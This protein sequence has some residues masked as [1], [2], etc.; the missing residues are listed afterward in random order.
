[1]LT[2]SPIFDCVFGP[3]R[4]SRRSGWRRMQGFT[5]VELLAVL[6]IVGVLAGILIPVVAGVRDRSRTAACASNLRQIGIGFRVYLADNKGLGLK[7]YI[8]SGSE[9]WYRTLLGSSTSSAVVDSNVLPACPSADV[10]GSHAV[11]GGY[12]M[13]NLVVWYPVPLHRVDSD[14]H[15]FST[16]LQRPQDWPLFMDADTPIIYGLDNPVE[17]AAS[18][19]RF[20]ARHGGKANVLM[21]DLHMESVGYGDSRWSQSALN[22]GSYYTP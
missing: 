13:T 15:F 22:S 7:S 1:M 12:G 9:Y 8:S 21:A 20:A 11:A 6:A 18:S 17:S 3:V 14:P 16:R 19:S 5:L 4:S 10:T 2:S